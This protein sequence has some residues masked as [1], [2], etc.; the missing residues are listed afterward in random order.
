[1]DEYYEAV[2]ALPKWL[3]EPLRQLPQPV[4]AQIQEVRIRVGCTLGFTIRGEQCAAR[5]LPNIPNMAN[6]AQIASALQ[7]GRVNEQQIEEIFYTLCKGSVHSYQEELAQGYLTLAG[8]HRVG[9]G[10]KYLARDASR[11]GP[12]TL[13]QKVYSLNLRIAR[14]R[15]V[16]LPPELL[17]ILQGRFTGLLVLGEPGSGKTTL[18]REIARSLAAQ[19]RAVAVVDEREEL[20]PAREGGAAIPALD[21]IAGLPKRKAV[22]MAL[23]TL[24][25]QVIL[26]DELG[27]L[28]EAAALEQGFFSGVDFVASLHAASWE[29]ALRRPQVRYLQTHGMVRAAALLEGRTAP[30]RIS[31]V[32]WL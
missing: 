9:V 2:A 24:G 25:P 22:Q 17:A 18:L 23:R 14:T 28:D 30:G 32:R 20:F 16:E 13:L 7:E 27:G 29:E 4:A 15:A 3:A 31:E 8:G 26:L 1:M 12:N 11:D 19:N 10:G 6:T 21:C 5:K